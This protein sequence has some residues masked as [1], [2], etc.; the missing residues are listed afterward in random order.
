MR[1][2]PCIDLHDGAVKQIV[3]STL[4]DGVA[5]ETNFVAAQPAAYFASLYARDALPGGHVIM[6]GGGSANEAAAISALKAFPGGLQ[7]GGGITPANAHRFLEAGA[8]HVIVT[9]YVFREGR[10]DW[11]RLAELERTVG[12]ERLVLDVSCRKRMTADGECEFLV[13][14]DRW[15]TWTTE[16]VTPAFLST[17][18]AHCAEILVHAVDVEG[19]R[20][21]VDDA[22]V[23][24]LGTAAAA[25]GARPI[26]YAGG[27]R[28]LTD[29]E[30]VS[31]LGGGLVDISI[32]SALDIFGGS[33]PYDEV[34]QWSKVREEGAGTKNL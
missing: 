16:V 27:V 33:F 6:L 30:R 11:E 8:S 21:G 13:M 14:T 10:I 31:S 28:D 19:K 18:S 20:A 22:L 25:P 2:R 1:F 34:V 7:V 17:L 24:L 5:L 12:K 9:S 26:T 3:G 15:A 32:G 4:G 23:R 29:V